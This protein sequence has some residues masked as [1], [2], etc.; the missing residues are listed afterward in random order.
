MLA[1]F[2]KTVRPHGR[3]SIVLQRLPLSSCRL[4]VVVLLAAACWSVSG[5]QPTINSTLV[6]SWELTQAEDLADRVGQSANEL[7]SDAAS[8]RSNVPSDDQPLESPM[9]I[10]F[11]GDGKLETATNMGGIQSQKQGTWEMKSAGPP[12]VIAFVING[13][14]AETE[15]EWIGNDQIKMVPPNMAG[16]TMKLV[17]RRRQSSN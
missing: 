10:R 15:I 1:G 11:G 9:T 13:Q 16:L 5:C 4:S 7:A 17:F 3:Q 8:G 6:G 2:H 14:P 12:M